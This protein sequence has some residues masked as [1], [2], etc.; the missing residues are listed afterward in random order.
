MDTE[1][2][3]TGTGLI[4][5]DKGGLGVGWSSLVGAFIG[6][7]VGLM[8]MQISALRLEDPV[9]FVLCSCIAASYFFT[10]T[11]VVINQVIEAIRMRGNEGS[12]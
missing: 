4:Y 11:A 10:F 1:Q 6:L 5:S 2:E 7:V 9:L 8:L 3:V 12:K